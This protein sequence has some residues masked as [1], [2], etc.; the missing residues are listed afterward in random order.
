MVK[1]M[2]DWISLLLGG[3]IGATLST[4][5][6]H[7]VKRPKLTC[8]GGG[9]GGGAYKSCHVAIG[10]P[11]GILGIRVNETS[12]FG[13]R[14]H[15][16]RVFGL[17][18]FRDTAKNC[19]ATMKEIGG[20]ERTRNL[21]WRTPNLDKKWSQSVDISCGEKAELML[22]SGDT[23]NP[24]LFSIFWPKDSTS[25]EPKLPFPSA[26]FKAPAEFHVSIRSG[27]AIVFSFKVQMKRDVDG[28]LYY[29]TPSGGG[30][31]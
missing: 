13:W 20:E 1:M 22:F 12:L 26:R 30:T 14:L 9:G 11:P 10:N 3:L 4:V 17:T 19:H 2:F 25:N 7:Y 24:E 18:V 21:F 6:A 8:E 16:D 28:R 29:S 23:E 15:G 27:E 5:H 31:F